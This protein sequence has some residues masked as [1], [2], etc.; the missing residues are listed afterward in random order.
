MKLYPGKRSLQRSG[1]RI[2]LRR[3]EIP[4]FSLGEMPP[5]PPPMLSG[6]LPSPLTNIS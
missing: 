5:D 1:L 2:S 6:V 4:I 3:S